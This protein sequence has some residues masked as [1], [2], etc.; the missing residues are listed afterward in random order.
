MFNYSTKVF[1][2]VTSELIPGFLKE[3]SYLFSAVFSVLG[4][5]MSDTR[6]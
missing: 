4:A 1:L 6:K 3:L 2:C 5:E